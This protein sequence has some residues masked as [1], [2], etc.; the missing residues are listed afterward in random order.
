MPATHSHLSHSFS[1]S[2]WVW[3]YGVK[4]GERAADRKNTCRNL[5]QIKHL[6]GQFFKITTFGIAFFLRYH[7]SV[8]Y[9]PQVCSFT[10]TDF[11]DKVE[12]RRRSLLLAINGALLSIMTIFAG[13]LCICMHYVSLNCEMEITIV[14]QLL[15]F[16]YF[17]P[18][19]RV[20]NSTF[21]LAWG[22]GFCPPRT[23][24]EDFILY[25]FQSGDER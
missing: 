23:R 14:K 8:Y 5:R 7:G 24:G 15:P 12:K 11:C 18:C 17:F 19:L 4:G 21:N 20:H 3:E 22:F 16:K 10:S 1:A 2:G 9:R 25:V 13:L 6:T